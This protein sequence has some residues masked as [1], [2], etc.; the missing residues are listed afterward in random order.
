M[1]ILLLGGNGYIGS[2]LYQDLTKIYSIDSIDLCLFGKNLG[3]SKVVNYKNV[4]I[5]QYD[6]VICLAGHSSVQM[7][8]ISAT[9]S[10]QN[11]VEN[12]INLCEKVNKNQLL[13]Y[14]SSASV[15]GNGLF[16][17]TEDSSINFNTINNYDLQKIT[18][19]LISNRYISSGK[20]II[21]LRFGT[22]NGPSPNTRGELMLNSMVK[23]AIDTGSI[24]IKNIPIRRAILGINDLSRAIKAILE[25]NIPSGQYNLSS[26][27]S[28]VDQMAKMVSK[29]LN[30][31]ITILPNDKS[32]YDFEM[33]TEKFQKYA[34]FEFQDTLESIVD[35]L[36]SNFDQI[37]FDI[38]NDDRDFKNY[39]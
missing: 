20:N 1:K 14:A 4:D 25:K 32:A 5:E 7:S 12:F 30:A 39:V 36:K 37:V 6:V 29:K 26:F 8:E 23:S 19:D 11:N 27:N 17:S 13:I 21:G 38:R 15:Y 33:C 35:D 2:R 9:R 22:V 18:I 31:K 16:V 34:D 28:T 10:W 24:N 3:Y